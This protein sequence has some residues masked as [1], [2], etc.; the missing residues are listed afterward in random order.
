M[1]LDPVPHPVTTPATASNIHAPWR[2]QFL[3][4]SISPKGFVIRLVFLDFQMTTGRTAV[5]DG[6]NLP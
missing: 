4:I 2:T 1:L 5:N 3:A 6:L